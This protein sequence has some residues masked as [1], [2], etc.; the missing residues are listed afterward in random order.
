MK[1]R[2]A[3]TIIILIV[4][5]LIFGSIT[6]L[7]VWLLNKYYDI[8]FWS[9]FIIS[10]SIELILFI[11]SFVIKMSKRS[12]DSLKNI[13]PYLYSLKYNNEK[14]RLSFAYLIRIKVNNRYLLVKSGHKRDLFGPVGGVYH[15]EH[16]DYVYNTLG[17]ARDSTP[18]DSQDVRGTILGKNI[19][20]FIEWFNHGENRET[21]PLREFCEELLE[22][23]FIPKQLFDN[24]T[25][26]FL[27]TKYKGISFNDYY[28]INELL[29]FDIYE[30]VLNE[31]QIKYIEDGN[32]NKKSVRLFSKEEI[33]SLGIT[34]EN[35][36]R[37]IGT[38]TPYILED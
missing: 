3:R 2:I 11:L 23:E 18:G 22:S 36:K 8:E 5:Y 35:D 9:T 10:L 20:K 14:I 37:I 1:K 19:E 7:I 12:I 15:I 26:S 21:S 29:R 32:I 17:F 4:S 33:E 13:R 31:E 24:P 27:G 16:I 25:F 6:F 28:H 38:Q 30:L 34:E